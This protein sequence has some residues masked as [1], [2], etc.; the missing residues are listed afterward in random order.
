MKTVSIIIPC[1][2]EEEALPLY[3]KAV[4]LVLKNIKDYKIDFILVNDGSKDR[5]LEIMNKLYEERDDITIVNQIRNFGQN[6]ALLAGYESNT[7]DYIISMDVDLQDPVEIIPLILEKFSQGYEVV[8]PHRV[9]RT[10]DSL[11]KKQSAGFFYKFINKLEGKSVLPE[12]VNCF[13]GLS[14]NIVNYVLSLPD[15]DKYLLSAIPYVSYKE[16]TIDFKR[17]QRDAGKSKYNLP[18]LIDYA[19]NNISSATAKPLYWPIKF[20]A[21]SAFITILLAITFTVFYILGLC[22]I[23]FFANSICF[24]VFYTL[25]ILSYI[26]FGVSVCVCFIGLIGIYLHN[27]LINTRDRQTYFIESVKRP[28]DKSKKSRK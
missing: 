10:K 2:N 21:I 1:Y 12:N 11:L 28:S 7:S 23:A 15:K 6:A 9:D 25:M 13:R 26:F 22:N 24:N 19:C 3:F 17:D 16:V 18:K 4:D 5:T 14:K 27:I 20:G 8:N